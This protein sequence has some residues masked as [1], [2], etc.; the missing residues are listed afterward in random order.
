MQLA[1]RFC[2][3]IVIEKKKKRGKVRNWLSS[4]MAL[5]SQQ[6]PP[7]LGIGS[8]QNFD[9]AAALRGIFAGPTHFS[10]FNQRDEK[11]NLRKINQRV[12]PL[13]SKSKFY[14]SL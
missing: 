6:I 8:A 7:L 12:P 14:S 4:Y 3:A 5:I 9:V 2:L 10:S 1:F 13:L 11:R